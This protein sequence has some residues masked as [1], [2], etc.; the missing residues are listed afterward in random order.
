MRFVL[1]T[2]GSHGDVNPYLTIARALQARGHEA[3]VATHA[4]Y[5]ALVEGAGVALHPLRPDY[6]AAWGARVM[7]PRRGGK[8][9]LRDIFSAHA[10]DSYDDLRA[11]VAGADLFLSHPLTLVA[12][13]VAATSGVPWASA[14]L[15]PVSFLSLAADMPLVDP[16][17]AAVRERL[18]WLH[19]AVLRAGKRI[20]RRWV[21]PVEQLRAA[22]GV[23]P[24]AHPVFEGQHAPDLVLAL[25]SPLL[26]APQPDWP[27]QT[28]VTGAVVDDAVH[29]VAFAD[30]AARRSTD[31]LPPAL[32]RFL[33]EA[34]DGTPPSSSPSA[35]RRCS[36]RRPPGSTARARRRPARSV[37]APC[38]SPGTTRATSPPGWAPT[39]SPCR[40][41]RTRR[42]FRARPPWCTRAGW[43]R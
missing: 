1:A 23:A 39:C 37:A 7:H 15:A 3:V 17:L 30:G 28:L 38:C 20:A 21:A 42:S 29:G 5:R 9:L 41:R 40:R 43:A 4:H 25:F 2:V 18:P 13:L 14:V 26:A 33:D 19:R 36:P 10:R 16:A 32:A 27:R 34:S 8:V 6:D 35:P 31:A 11:A 22:L 12:P 24:G